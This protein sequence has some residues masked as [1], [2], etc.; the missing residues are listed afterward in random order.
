MN[1]Q[2]LEIFTYIVYISLLANPYNF[3]RQILKFK[4]LLLSI[5][6]GLI[7]LKNATYIVIY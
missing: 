1:C 2:M 4:K 6:L 3:M 5:N 7:I